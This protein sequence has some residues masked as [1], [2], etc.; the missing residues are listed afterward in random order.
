MVGPSKASVL[1][2]CQKD[3]EAFRTYPFRNKFPV[4]DEGEA[5]YEAAL[6]GFEKAS[7]AIR[8]CMV[9]KG[10]C[11]YSEGI[12]D[13]VLAQFSNIS[14]KFEKLSQDKAISEKGVTSDALGKLEGVFKR[15]YWQAIFKCHRDIAENIF[16]AMKE[17]DADD[18]ASLV[19]NL[20]A[21][22][23][24]PMNEELFALFKHVKGDDR[25]LLILMVE[26]DLY[27]DDLD[28]FFPRD[29]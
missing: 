5:A 17:K 25:Q 6:Q 7:D 12:F 1:S 9:T 23:V 19:G 29:V 24:S 8:N 28:I 16:R 13:S 26:F 15:A 14:I 21:D 11:K 3:I 27:E 22:K 10:G 20:K 18:I 4:T 2:P